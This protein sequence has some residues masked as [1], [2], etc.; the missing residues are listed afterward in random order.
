MWIYLNIIFSKNTSTNLPSKYASK[1]ICDK[2]NVNLH[3]TQIYIR[4]YNVQLKTIKYKVICKQLMCFRGLFLTPSTLYRAGIFI[5][6]FYKAIDILYHSELNSLTAC[7]SSVKM[8]PVFK[9]V[10]MLMNRSK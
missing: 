5:T 1:Y 7:A 10:C 9:G 2:D 6:I 8:F 4:V 3:S